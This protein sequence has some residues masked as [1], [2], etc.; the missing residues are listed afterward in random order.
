[1]KRRRRKNSKHN[2]SVLE[3]RQ[4]LATT[5]LAQFDG[6]ASI[7]TGLIVNGN[8][9]ANDIPDQTSQRV[10]ITNISGWSQTTGASETASLVGFD[11]SPRGTGLHLDDQAGVLESVFQDVNT[12]S[13]QL[14]TLAFDLLGRPVDATASADT[15]DVRILW[16]GAEVGTFRGIN[17]FWQ[18]F[19]VNVTGASSDLTRLEI[20]EVDG[21]G[22]D[23]IGV[24]LDNLRL[25]PVSSQT[26]E[27]GSFEDNESGVVSHDDVPGWN[28][29][30]D[31]ADR[32]IDIQDGTGSEGT[33]FLNLDR[34]DDS[35]D[36]VFANVPTEAGG[37][38]F[39]SFDLRSESG[40]VGE[41]EEVRIRWNDEWVGTYRGSQEWQGHGFTVRADSESTRLVFREPGNTFTGDGDGP[42][43]DNVRIT[44][45]VP[46]V[47]LSLNDSSTIAF[48]ENGADVDL[49][50]RVDAINSTVA[51]SVT[52]IT[53]S[54][55]ADANAAELLRVQD[56]ATTIQSV[57]GVLTIDSSQT[58][59]EFLAVL[60]T[61]EYVNTSDNP[62]AGTR[63]ITIEV[64]AAGISSPST[65]MT[66]NV[67]AVNDAPVVASI[68]DATAVVDEA[69]TGQA[70][71]TDAE[72]DSLTWSISGTGSAIESGD[73]QPTIDAD[74]N[75][76]WT[77]QRAG[78]AVMT[79]RATDGEGLFD[80]QTF[81]VT[82]NTETTID[83][84]TV[85]VNSGTD[86]PLFDA[87]AATDPAIG[88]TIADFDA[89]TITGGEFNSIEPGVARIYS[90]LAHWCPFCQQELPEIVEWME[91]ANLGDDVEFVA[92]A[93]SVDSTRDNY[94]PADWFETEE[95]EGTIIV[96]N[97][98]NKL[99][100]LLG[101][102]S[103]PFLVAVDASGEVVDRFSGIS[104]SA[105][106]DAALAAI[107]GS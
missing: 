92:A 89:Q 86:L 18:T 41:D 56:G 49:G 63:A 24:M 11:D 51:D 60:Q 59:A 46:N 43:L 98:A 103:F 66:I 80:E 68:S 4:L 58:N 87:T 106:L 6:D 21:T 1:M 44:K 22:N 94:P 82:A 32:L 48:T 9:D 14:Y 97:E 12:E 27:N 47:S 25:V 88:Q 77:P 101:T 76:S 69:F 35:S 85:L 50:S 17:D 28:V 64:D 19:T 65:T 104:T 13:G 70:T 102:Q 5:G 52:S 78:S 7:D 15:N 75:I 83:R 90:V 29:T 53:V 71:A 95:F 54:L 73:P 42:Q 38:Y 40:D 100:D 39:V 31:E 61:L 3:S 20:S 105:Q 57:D 37:I 10:E 2:Y 23:G 34:M 36:I 8:F 107:R 30:A 96:D 99:M 81:T 16:D 33:R 45:V 26:L 79:V 62:V 72:S 55:P 93:V 74:G 91:D 67:T 84:G